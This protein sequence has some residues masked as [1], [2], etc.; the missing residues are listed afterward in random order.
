M[1][2]RF[3]FYST[4]TTLFF[5]IS[6]ETSQKKL[7]EWLSELKKT[8]S[9]AE[10]ATNMPGEYS[11]QIKRYGELANEIMDDLPR[12]RSKIDIIRCGQ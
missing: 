10:K 2:G 6:S 12:V 1:Q 7:A 4:P 5:K 3:K 9:L 8:L 11:E